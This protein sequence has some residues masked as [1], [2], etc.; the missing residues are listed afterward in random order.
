M[1][2]ADF[3]AIAKWIAELINVVDEEHGVTGVLMMI[4]IIV[5]V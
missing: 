4:I 1:K 2:R 3:V 5:V